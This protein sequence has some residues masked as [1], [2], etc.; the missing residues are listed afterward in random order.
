MLTEL[1]RNAVIAFAEA[2]MN[3]NQAAK[4]THYHHN[5]IRFHLD[6]VKKQ[7]GLDPRNFFDL[8]E[9]YKIATEI[10]TH[11]NV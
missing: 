1:Q 8:Q 3:A 7:T 4:A 9:L 11:D 2:G 5:T 10:D 6:N